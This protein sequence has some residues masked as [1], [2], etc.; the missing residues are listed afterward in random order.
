[1]NPMN[2]TIKQFIHE[3]IRSSVL[4]LILRLFLVMF[5]VDTIYSIAEIYFLDLD[6]S[7]DIHRLITTGMFIAHF[8]KNMLLIYLV[9]SIITKWISNL[10]YLTNKYLVKHEGILNIKEKMIDL[11]NLRSVTV[12]QGFLGKLFNYGNITLTTSASGGYA[13]EIYL[14]EIDNP[15]KYN[16]FFQDC[17]EKA[18]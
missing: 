16:E 3:P 14:S 18:T 13:E 4:I 6:V 11:K 5:V 15:E 17:L 9:L 12:N 7:L 8:F 10:C 1:M 2:E